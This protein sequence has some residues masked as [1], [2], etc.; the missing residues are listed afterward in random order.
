MQIPKLKKKKGGLIGDIVGGVGGLVI[1]V[2]ITLIVI[3]TLIG[4]NLLKGGVPETKVSN[5]TINL[6]SSAGLVKL[7]EWN[8]EY[9]DYTIL[10]MWNESGADIDI[11]ASDYLFNSL[12][13]TLTN[14]SATVYLRGNVTY[15]Y[16]GTNY[17]ED[18]VLGMKSNFTTGLGNVSSKLPVILLIAAVVLLFSVLVI[19]IARSKQMGTSGGSGSL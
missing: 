8:E 3:G 12:T 18:S 16:I 13:G 10:H 2:V 6:N 14:G 7:A 9:H 1:L 5:E 19:L 4:A 11:P 17:Y 15:T